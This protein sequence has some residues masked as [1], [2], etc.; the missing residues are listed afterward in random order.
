MRLALV[1]AAA[2]AFTVPP[3]GRVVVTRRSVAREPAA[4]LDESPDERRGWLSIVPLPGRRRAGDEKKKKKRGE[5]RSYL[6]DA[7]RV[8]R[9]AARALKQSSSDDRATS[10]T[11]TDDDEEDKSSKVF[12][13]GITPPTFEA[14]A[15]AVAASNELLVGRPSR[16]RLEA[17]EADMTVEEYD[18]SDEGSVAPALFG[19]SDWPPLDAVVAAQQELEQR[20]R[21]ATRQATR[22]KRQQRKKVRSP[23]GFAMCQAAVTAAVATRSRAEVGRFCRDAE[24]VTLLVDAVAQAAKQPILA[25]P[26][27]DAAA[28][29]AADALAHLVALDASTSEAPLVAGGEVNLLKEDEDED[30]ETVSVAAFLHSKTDL[31]AFV[32][33]LLGDRDRDALRRSALRLALRLSVVDDAARRF[34][35][36]DS[37]VR[38][39]VRRAQRKANRPDRVDS[40]I[41]AARAAS[42]AAV[43]L[44]QDRRLAPSS[45]T[46]TKPPLES[47]QQQQQNTSSSFLDYVRNYV[48]FNTQKNETSAANETTA[49]TPLV[50]NAS[51]L[52]TTTMTEVGEEEDHLHQKDVAV[53][54]SEDD[55]AQSDED[56]PAPLTPSSQRPPPP[57]A[58]AAY[59]RRTRGVLSPP[60]ATDGEEKELRD[61]SKLGA[62]LGLRQLTDDSVL[63]KR[64]VRV[65]CLD[66]GGTRGVV[67]IE[68]LRQLQ[69]RCFP[70]LEVHEAFDLVVGTSTGAILAVLL[71]AR[72]CTLDNAA[73]LYDELVARIFVKKNIQGNTMLVLRRAFY[74]ERDIL[75]VF[76]ELLGDDDLLDIAEPP[77]VPAVACLATLL[78]VSPARVC[79]L[80]N[81]EYP[82]AGRRRTKRDD[83]FKASSQSRQKRRRQQSSAGSTFV[84][85]TARTLAAVFLKPL[86]FV[87]NAVV[88]RLTT[89]REAHSSSSRYA[90]TTRLAVRDALR[91]ATAA[92]TLFTPVMVRGQLLCDGAL[93][94]NNPAAIAC[95]EAR[96]LFPDRRVETV[97]SVGTGELAPTK[98]ARAA[99]DWGGIV[100]QLVDSATSTNI[101]HDVLADLLGPHYWRFNP[102]VDC[103]SIDATDVATLDSFKSAARTYFDDA[104][105]ARRTTALSKRFTRVS[106]FDHRRERP[107]L[108]PVW[109]T[110][111]LP[112]FSFPGRQRQQQNAS[113]SPAAQLLTRR[114]LRLRGFLPS[115]SSSSSIAP[116]QRDGAAASLA[117]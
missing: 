73:K 108:R 115:S 44:Y 85:S 53:A 81:Y 82:V 64:G 111:R 65:L 8:D 27:E 106:G 76:D 99:L 13:L 40:R 18:V 62:A 52:A 90:G 3:P 42:A 9:E 61:A 95:H 71:G 33:S 83:I 79:L 66:G 54:L 88:R 67:T 77:R 56:T 26:D 55:D 48:S 114:Q 7:P 20:L 97:V 10:A 1:L 69:K 100:N 86:R 98:T 34:L 110:L 63:K 104:T 22:M 11:E 14:L 112:A 74:D 80:R 31:T 60:F 41:R 24:L 49:E 89:P 59:W 96:A 25:S 32:A 87:T 72:Q 36:T 91:A 78:S 15:R 43:K 51:V 12:S 50:L 28:V 2:A 113:S 37:R 6:V 101:V 19:E 16:R 17:L 4:V 39:F 35:A 70:G 46:T 57:T 30:H 29:A 107:F 93:I 38:T 109:S 58:S 21:A 103:G 94:S 75:A 84:L 68:L 5:R 117:A 102:A 23:G 47:K 105:V 116:R 45:V 92:P